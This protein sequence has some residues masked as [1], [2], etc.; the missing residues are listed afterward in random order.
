MQAMHSE[1]RKI[2]HEATSLLKK[3]LNIDQL[4]ALNTLEQFGWYLKF[5]RHDPPRPPIGVLCDPDKHTYAILDELGELH[6][7][8]VFENFR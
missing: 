6:E 7:N 3:K 8:P 4:A 2:D 1:R 5:V